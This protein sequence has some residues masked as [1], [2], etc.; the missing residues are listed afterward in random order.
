MKN[1]RKKLLFETMKGFNKK[2]KSEIFILGSE[3]KELNVI[4]SGIKTIDDFIGGGFKRGAHSIIWGTYS[5]GKTALVLQ[6]IAN[7]QKL[8]KLVCY[9]N[10]EKPIDPE[11]FKFFGINLNEMIYIEAPECAEDALE[12]MRT[13]CKNKVI[14]L[15]I[16]DS[17]N[18]LCP[19][20]VQKTAKGAERG[21]KKKNVAALPLALS[22]FYN[23][24]NSHIFRSKA[25]IVWIGQARTKGIGGFF[26]YLGL[27]GGN[28]QEFYA[29]QIMSM[30][31]GE[32]RNSPVKKF[33]EYFFDSDKKLRYETV[34]DKIGFDVIVQLTKT[35]SI[36]SAKRYSKIHIPFLD[37]KGFVDS[38]E[39]NNNIPIRIDP[40]ASKEDKAEIEKLLIE[41]GVLQ[42]KD[43]IS[44]ETKIEETI[45]NDERLKDKP[46]KKK[47]GRPKKK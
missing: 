23:I 6:T 29:Y 15:F 36:K 11:R 43:N 12:A 2:H 27:T 4:P 38:V 7:A 46:I 42:K 20:S 10:T 37:S 9:V 16:I 17:T 34:D 22:N 25:A 35:N 19:K 5:I 26:A 24:V 14:D 32:D 30:K 45:L 18:G 21:L 13:L 39:E 28:A 33:K 3:I 41:K 44:T 1:E 47:K 31:K 40:T 8:G